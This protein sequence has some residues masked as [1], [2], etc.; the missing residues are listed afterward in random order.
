LQ[1]SLFNFLLSLLRNRTKSRCPR[2]C[3]KPFPLI[4]DFSSAPWN[5]LFLFPL[6]EEWDL[7]FLPKFLRS[8]LNS[9]SFT[10]YS[11]FR[12][13]PTH[14]ASLISLHYKSPPLIDSLSG[15]PSPL[16]ELYPPAVPSPLP[17]CPIPTLRFPEIIPPSVGD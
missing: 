11:L 5:S 6:F 14:L 7:S 4:P 15:E 17:F 1:F 12:R 13:D 3:P 2:N 10:M 16:I 8:R 9:C